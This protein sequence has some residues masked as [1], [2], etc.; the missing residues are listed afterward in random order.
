MTTFALQILEAFALLATIGTAA[1]L[2]VRAHGRRIFIVV[3]ALNVIATVYF[4]LHSSLRALPD[5]DTA[6]PLLLVQQGVVVLLF[7]ARLAST[8]VWAN[9]TRRRP[10]ALCVSVIAG[11]G[12]LAA[13][14]LSGVLPPIPAERGPDGAWRAA[15]S[16]PHV[17]G[18]ILTAVFLGST[19]LLTILT[20][21]A[22]FRGERGSR[23]SQ[24]PYGVFLAVATFLPLVT[25]FVAQANGLD[26]HVLTT[27]ATIFLPLTEAA[28]LERTVPLRLRPSIVGWDVAL[29]IREALFLVDD[30]GTVDFANPRA[31]E[32]LGWDPTGD[33]LDKVL[34]ED[35]ESGSA[36]L[37][38]GQGTLIPVLVSRARIQL[39]LGNHS[40]EV[41]SVTDISRLHAAME[42]AE[43]AARA[44]SDFLAVMS[45]EIRTPMNAVVGLAHLLS[46]TD[47]DKVQS[48]W[49]WTIRQSADAL[50]TVI[51]DILDLSRIESGRFAVETVP[52]DPH[53]TLTDC[54]RVVE[55]EARDRGLT[56]QTDLT[57]MP[58]H[59]L[60]DATR[61]RQV[62]LNLLTNAIKFTEQGTVTLRAS[63]DDDALQ[64]DIVDTG[65]GIAEDQQERLFQA[66][67]QAD[68]ST[69]RRHGG[70]GLGLTIS[71]RLARLMGG[72]L[73]VQS[74]VG[75]GSTFRMRVRTPRAAL[76]P[77]RT[78]D[79]HLALG[80][81]LNVLVVEDNPVNQKVARALLEREGAHVAVAGNGREG[82]RRCLSER[83]DLVLM[84][85]Q[86][87]VMDGFEAL[88][89]LRRHLPE[90][91]AP[92]LV[93]FSA[94]V[95]PEDRARSKAAGADDHL[96]KPVTPRALQDCLREASRR[97]ELRAPAAR[98]TA[99][100]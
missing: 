6:E 44:R 71:R 46:R 1:W 62:V 27:I 24:V 78:I 9:P 7:G 95:L 48:D 41:L 18:L 80:A 43:R 98:R 50:L 79:E 17:T 74:E 42:D 51:N 35:E 86:M 68:A 87:P 99:A 84:D 64:I 90:N 23:A 55:E 13:L 69:T 89:A 39:P 60:G 97:R 85:L 65:P 33:R 40:G 29:A 30:F 37:R 77:P 32:L 49:V 28:I 5:A 34:V 3:G 59:V 56:L 96:S 38:T 93:A 26:T 31:N 82:V 22:I 4:A 61:V 19:A 91:D 8:W 81:P 54:I 53:R 63:W 83:F 2:F 100:S 16:E 73:T 70:T 92:L 15:M 57:R 47:L 94:N 75:V 10:P 52:F 12:V 20:F 72:D 25:E 76:P 11:I 88:R 67:E 36:W 66:F 45:H 14:F 58:R 21:Q